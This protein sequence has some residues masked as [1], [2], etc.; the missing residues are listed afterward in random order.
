MET[1]LYLATILVSIVLM[2]VILLQSKGSGFSGAFGGDPSSI[3]RTRRG[4]ERTL[5]QF[6]IGVAAV[7]VLLAIVSSFYL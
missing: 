2:L 4:L 7:Y 3:Y 1:A 6:T 5:F